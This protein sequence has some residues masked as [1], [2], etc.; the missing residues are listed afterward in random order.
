MMCYDTSTTVL[1][2]DERIE[3]GVIRNEDVI[4]SNYG[5]LYLEALERLAAEI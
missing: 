5:I 4:P 3:V 2:V 1:N